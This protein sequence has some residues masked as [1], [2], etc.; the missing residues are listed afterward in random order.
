MVVIFAL[1]SCGVFASTLGPV[2]WVVISELF[3]NRIRGVAVSF[4]V[5]SLW[6]ANFVL[7]VSFPTLKATLGP[8]GCFAVYAEIC[9]C[10]V[11]CIL[12]FVPETKAKSL[13]EIEHELCAN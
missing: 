2:V 11:L 7:I 13:E 5:A 8:A 12:R 9:L 3:P 1:A 6:A 10:G 4:A